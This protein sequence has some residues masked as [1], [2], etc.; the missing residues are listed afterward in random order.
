MRLKRVKEYENGGDHSVTRRNALAGL[1]SLGLTTAGAAIFSGCGGAAVTDASLGGLTITID[2]PS[3]PSASASITFTLLNGTTTT[4]S[5]TLNRPDSGSSSTYT[6]TSLPATILTIRAESFPS[7][8]GVGVAQA[9]ASKSITVVAGINTSMTITMSSTI[10]SLSI[11]PSSPSIK[12]GGSVQLGMS[13]LNATGQV[14]LTSGSTVSWTSLTTDIAS[15][16]STGLVVGLA[17]GVAQIQVSESDSGKSAT[18]N[19]VVSATTTS[20]HLIPTETDGPYPLYSVLANSAMIRS[21][22][23]ETQTGVP[24]TVELTLVNVNGTCAVVPNAYVYI[25]HCNK[26][27]QY[28]GYSSSQNGSHAGETFCRGIQVSDSSG[29]VTF[30]TVYPGWYSGRITHVHLQVYVSTL[31]Q[32]NVTVT[33]QFGFP[34]DIT[35]AVY[36]STL[37]SAHG[38][39]TSIT[40]FAQDGIFSDGT[41]FQIVEVT[42]NVSSGYTA[43][44]EIGISI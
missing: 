29:K 32:S 27:G 26:D 2:W 22:I 21:S 34:Q 39:N 25:W 38:Q 7:A 17:A 30:T 11:T 1:T 5:Q 20:C 18:V 15:V 36:N 31:N 28:S 3:I 35:T 10:S 43:K 44:L 12:V 19:I 42:G 6:F 40:S 41:Q 8:N 37:Y 9:S 14:V 33:S 16:S 23:N 4:A 13:A 24:L